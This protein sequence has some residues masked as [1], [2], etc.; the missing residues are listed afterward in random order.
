MQPSSR[1]YRERTGKKTRFHSQSFTI[2]NFIIITSIS[3]TM[4]IFVKLLHKAT[5]FQFWIFMGLKERQGWPKAIQPK[6]KI[7]KHICPSNLHIRS[8]H[9][10]LFGGEVD[11]LMRD[12]NT[13]PF[14]TLSGL[15]HKNFHSF[16]ALSGPLTQG[17]SFLHKLNLFHNTNMAWFDG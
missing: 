3:N 14:T 10:I 17:C 6:L 13:M 8:I 16:Q 11:F 12:V 1:L 4:T 2:Y 9:R 5:L 15:N 7:S